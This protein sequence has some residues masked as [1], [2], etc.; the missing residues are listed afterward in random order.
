VFALAV[1]VAGFLYPYGPQ[2]VGLLRHVAQRVAGP[3][4]FR[5]ATVIGG[6]VRAVAR[7]VI[8]VA[9]LQA[10]LT[11]MVFLGA[12]VPHAG[13]LT[14]LVTV[15]CIMQVGAL[16]VVI[17][18]LLWSFVNWPLPEA[19]TL[20]LLLLPISLAE[21]VVRPVLAGKGSNLPLPLLFLGLL[22]GPIAFGLLGLFLGP[23]ILSVIYALV[24]EDIGTVQTEGALSSAGQDHSGKT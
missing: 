20:T 23:V 13:L 1:V 21:H 4:G 8:G 22:A 6:S 17:P 9:L 18:V 14:M 15:L 10:L 2:L 24:H 11:G 7:G 19:L 16:V 5:V 12:G 3:R